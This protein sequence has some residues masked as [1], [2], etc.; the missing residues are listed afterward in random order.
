MGKSIRTTVI[1][2][3]VF[4]IPLMFVLMILKQ[5]Y[6]LALAVAIPVSDILP[7]EK[8]AGYAVAS[9]LAALIVIA[10]C[11]GAGMLARS[12]II[13]N[14]IGKLDKFL[15]RAIPAY[16]FTKKDLI[17]TLGNRSFE[18]DWKV[19]LVGKPDDKRLL[20]FEVERRPN[21][22]VIVFQPNTPTIR[23]G[24]VWT[25]PAEQVELLDIKPR[26]LSALLKTYGIGASEVV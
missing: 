14:K 8:F 7:I 24:F 11:F 16:H 22:D 17:E 6:Q 23:T 25:V 19:V 1:G 12:S 3:I 26:Q 5:A 15:A 18:D 20:G 13:S 10:V 2:G 4:L 21:G 9:I